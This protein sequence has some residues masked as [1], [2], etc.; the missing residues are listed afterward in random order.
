MKNLLPV[1]TWLLLLPIAGLDFINSQWECMLVMFAALVL[2]PKGLGLMNVPY[3]SWY[4]LSAAGLC[5]GYLFD[6][7]GLGY[8]D[9]LALPYFLLAVWLT[10]LQ[11]GEL[12]LA[13]HRRATDW[14]AL[15]A[16]GYWATGAF[17]ALCFL[18]G[19]QPVGFDPVIVSLTAA[20]FHVAG[21]VLSVVVWRL[22][23]NQ[24]TV[25]NRVL[26]AGT[27]AG[28]PLVA[29]GITLS[30]LG[31]PN[32]IESAAAVGFA[33][34]ALLVVWQHLRLAFDKNYA[35]PARLYWLAGAACLLTGGAL[36]A[37]YGLRFQF[38]AEWVN[39]PNMKIWHG[40]LNTLGFG[41]LVL[42]G[43]ERQR[44]TST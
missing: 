34:L 22:F 10:L 21:F 12:F 14:L 38:P 23:E 43:W 36:A 1:C 32:W 37:I 44:A 13:S 15:F 5:A 3:P 29:L 41:W 39:I 11:G 30:K 4:W 28:M 25:A 16:L 19:F 20:H 7:H 35:S 8:T 18:A 9:A 33:A 27:M 31:Y 24:K 6:T 42:H 2:V 40:S 17:W 26:A